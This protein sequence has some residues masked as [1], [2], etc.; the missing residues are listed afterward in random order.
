[1]NKLTAFGLFAVIAMVVCYALEGHG[2]RYTFAFA[3][4]CLL[5]SAYGFLR[6]RGRSERWRL[7]GPALQ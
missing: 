1:M 6:E 4:A 7:S 2:H 5:G 3:I